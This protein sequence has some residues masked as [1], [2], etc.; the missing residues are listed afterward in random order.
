MKKLRLNLQEFESSEILSRDELRSIFGGSGSGLPGDSCFVSCGTY[1]N[2]GASCIGQN[3][4][5]GYVMV[6]GVV[7]SISCNGITYW[8]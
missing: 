2:M 8:C 3:G 6:G 7:T 1:P 4:N 5:C